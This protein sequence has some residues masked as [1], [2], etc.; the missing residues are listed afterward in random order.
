MPR[1]WGA[2]PMMCLPYL[3][4][5]GW[6]G[7]WTPSPMHFH[8]GWSGLTEGF[9]HGCY[10]TGDGRYES[11]GHQQGRKAPRQLNRTVQNAK[12]NHPVSSKATAASGQQHKQWVPKAVSYADGS[13][14]NQDQT[15]PMSK[16]SAN[17]DEAKHSTKKGPEEVAA[18]QNKV[19]GEET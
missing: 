6:Y 14:G 13:G 11:V 3:P 18:K 17:D 2:P 5:T 19:Q 9:G 8:P 10:Y 4:W 12:P 1:P 15:G 16:I 7:P